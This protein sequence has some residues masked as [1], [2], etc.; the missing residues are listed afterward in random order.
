MNR[1]AALLSMFW[2]GSNTA[3]SSSTP[4][5]LDPVYIQIIDR[6]SD[7]MQL[8]GLYRFL[9]YDAISVFFNQTGALSY[10]V[11][12]EVVKDGA[13]YWKSETVHGHDKCKLLSCGFSFPGGVKGV[14]VNRIL[15]L[16]LPNAILHTPSWSTHAQPLN[17]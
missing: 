10:I 1:R 13:V 16:E 7:W 14:T 4:T 11:I 2:G 12:L 5:P 8:T 15:I 9:P 3:L 17:L 6:T